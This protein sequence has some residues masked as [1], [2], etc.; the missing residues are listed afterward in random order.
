MRN[1]KMPVFCTM[2]RATGVLYSVKIRLVFVTEMIV[3]LAQKLLWNFGKHSA[4][5]VMSD[6]RYSEIIRR[7]YCADQQLAEMNRPAIN[8]TVKVTIGISIFLPSRLPCLEA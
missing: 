8:I 7:K 6:S 4:V 3:T 2:V 5:Y 1:L